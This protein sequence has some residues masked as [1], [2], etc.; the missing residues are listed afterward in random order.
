MNI[1][2]YGASSPDIA[3]IYSEKVFSLGAELAKRGHSLVYGGGANG[4]MGAAARGVTSKNGK[5]TGICPKFLNVDGILYD[6]CTEFIYTENMRERKRLMEE[7]SEG[8]VMVPGGIGTYEEFFEMLTLKQLGRHKKPIAIFNI[9]GYF[10][11]L[12]EMLKHTASEKFMTDGCLGLYKSF[13]DGNLLLDW[14]EAYKPNENGGIF[15][16]IQIR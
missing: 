8:F 15:K 10:D 6:K 3:P 1:C 11:M 4:L 7:K 13:D 12:D 5:L 2:L 16:N 9:N 14:L